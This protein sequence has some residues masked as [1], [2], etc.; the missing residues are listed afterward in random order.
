MKV[1]VIVV[2]LTSTMVLSQ[3]V[4]QPGH[5][6]K[7]ASLG[8][9]YGGGSSVKAATPKTDPLAVQLAKIEQQGPHIPS[10]TSRAATTKP[11]FPK[12]P[13]KEN[14]NKPMKFNGNVEPGGKTSQRH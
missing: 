1:V 8:K 12:T 14:R 7:H 6:S 11:L 10:S 2:V 5:T 3:T 13:A 4:K 9:H